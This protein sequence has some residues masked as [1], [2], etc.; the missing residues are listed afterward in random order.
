MTCKTLGSCRKGVRRA[1]LAPGRLMA[2][3]PSISRRIVP[4]P[5]TH[6][7]SCVWTRVSGP[8]HRR[9]LLLAPGSEGPQA[10]GMVRPGSIDRP[11]CLRLDLGFPAW[12]A[13]E[14]SFSLRFPVA[15]PLDSAQDR[16]RRATSHFKKF[17]HLPADSFENGSA[18]PG[19]C[20]YHP[21]HR[22]RPRIGHGHGLVRAVDLRAQERRL[23]LALGHHH[24]RSGRRRPLDEPFEQVAPPSSARQKYGRGWLTRTSVGRTREMAGR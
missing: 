16:V 20:A 11:S 6:S 15:T 4:Q 10:S 8:T 14:A 21:R 1:R 18:D 7:P 22:H 12:L 23:A 5:S 9:S 2:G 24:R 19:R 13:R 17:C 3:S